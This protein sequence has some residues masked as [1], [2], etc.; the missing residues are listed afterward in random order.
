VAAAD[1]YGV[2]FPALPPWGLRRQRRLKAEMEE[3]YIYHFPT[4]TPRWHGYW[5]VA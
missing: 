1:A 2:G 5:C 3:P 4:A